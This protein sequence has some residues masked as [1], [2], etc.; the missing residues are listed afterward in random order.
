MT[1]N[2]THKN[3]L[4]AVTCKH[5]DDLFNCLKYEKEVIKN[6]TVR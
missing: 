6:Q 2:E 4:H 1:P 3:H 5:S